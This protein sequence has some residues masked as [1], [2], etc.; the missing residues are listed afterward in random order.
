MEVGR[1][2]EIHDVS[3]PP[4]NMGSM[5]MEFMSQAYLRNRSSEIDI[6]VEVETPGTNQDH[7]LPIFLKVL[8]Q[9]S[10]FLLLF[11]ISTSA[12]LGTRL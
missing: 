5:H 12:V 8:Y 4:P 10:Y 3:L 11:K 9:S 7:P 6:E 2:D 1:Q